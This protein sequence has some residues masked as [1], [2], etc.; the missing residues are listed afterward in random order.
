MYEVK[1]KNG[2]TFNCDSGSTIFESAKASGI[3]LEHSCLTARC[4]SCVVQVLEGETENRVEEL[5]L[6][7]EEKTNKY[8]LSCNALPKSDLVLD[9]EDL[10]DIVI[11]EKKIFPT[12]IN[13][14]EKVTEDIAKVTLRFPP[15]A[16][17]KFI[18]GQYV[19]LIKGNIK[20]SYSIANM[21]TEK[22]ASVEFLIKNYTNGLMS[23]YWF[24]HAKEN[25]L[26]R[27]E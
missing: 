4:R 16:K 15:T 3:L 20:R 2:K 19:N 17:F 8:T 7:D 25:D 6:S 24:Q 10:G 5:V 22:N 26:I 21:P 12:K 13:T 18:S 1:L 23:N 9:V 27:L 11:H 14:I